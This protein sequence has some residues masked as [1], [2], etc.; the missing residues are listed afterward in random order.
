MKFAIVGYAQHQPVESWSQG[1]LNF[2]ASRRRDVKELGSSWV[3]FVCLATGYMLGLFQSG[4]L[5]E[6]QCILFETFLPGFMW[7]HAEQF[8]KAEEVTEPDSA[9]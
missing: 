2:V 8:T 5:N 3:E 9:S 6:Q 4:V 7:L 1:E